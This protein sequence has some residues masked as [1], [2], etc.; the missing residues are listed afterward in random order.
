MLT[1]TV[2]S[3]FLQMLCFTFQLNFTYFAVRRCKMPRKC[4]LCS[5]K[6]EFRK[7]RFI[8]LQQPT[9]DIS[10]EH[11]VRIKHHEL[12][13]SQPET[14]LVMSL[15]LKNVDVLKVSIPK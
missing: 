5:K 1:I 9:K 8:K 15:P 4:R 13:D 3:Y 2:Y 12:S 10:K 7:K 6:N 11:H 14:P